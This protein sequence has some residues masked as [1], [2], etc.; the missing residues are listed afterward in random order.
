MTKRLRRGQQ[1]RVHARQGESVAS[2]A[3]AYGHHPS[4][5]RNAG[6]NFKTF[7]DRADKNILSPGDRVFIPALRRLTFSVAPGR[8][9][10]VQVEVPR[11]ALRLVLT[12][13]DGPLRSVPFELYVGGTRVAA[14]STSS[15]GEVDVPL[16]ATLPL[17][18][19]A[20]LFVGDEPHRANLPLYLGA[21][22]PLETVAGLQGRLCNLGYH[23][24]PVD[25]QAGPM[26]RGAISSFQRAEGLPVTGEADA[27]TRSRLLRAHRV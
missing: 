12:G 15:A 9:T 23:P 19:T 16:P 26:T 17:C 14:G 22:D 3:A 24:G 18:A 10:T 4:S 8:E 13:R 6:E 25:G 1:G 27:T 5:L 2:I 11:P 7:S 20:H 21:L